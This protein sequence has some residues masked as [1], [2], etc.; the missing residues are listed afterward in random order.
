MTEGAGAFK[1]YI[2]WIPQSRLDLSDIQW[3]LYRS[4]LP[5]LIIALCFYSIPSQLLQSRPDELSHC[6]FNPLQHAFR[7]I[8]AIV[9]LV[10][11]HG[12]F[13]LHVLAACLLHYVCTKSALK[14]RTLCPLIA[15]TVP[16]AVWLL[17]RLHD[18]LP[19]SKVLPVLEFLDAYSGPVRW[20]IGFNLLALRM[21]S[22]SMD[23]HWSW[24][25]H[26]GLIPNKSEILYSLHS[27]GVV[28]SSVACDG[29]SLHDNVRSADAMN[30]TP[31]PS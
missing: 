21:I 24:L 14:Q 30:V 26:R 9:F 3:R 15:W 25:W 10:G 20:Q 19:F 13:A 11:L 17:A 5:Q 2:S 12:S 29:T 27:V 23:C 28:V 31:Q 6:H 8:S 4:S 16:S 22:W 18:G 1:T 7:I